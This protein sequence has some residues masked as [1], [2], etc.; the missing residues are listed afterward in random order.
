MELEFENQNH[1]LSA[2]KH[3][4][5]LPSG[6]DAGSHRSGRL[7][8]RGACGLLRERRRSCGAVNAAA[9]RLNLPAAYRPGRSI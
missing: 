6:A 5:R 3:R 7:A 1:R 8:G 2:A 9:A 4:G